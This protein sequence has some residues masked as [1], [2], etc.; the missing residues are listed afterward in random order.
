MSI[1]GIGLMSGTSL[2]GIDVAMVEI[3]GSDYDI[4]INLI[5]SDFLSYPSFVRELLLELCEPQTSSVDK[6]CKTNAYLG[7]LIGERVNHLIEKSSIPKEKICFVSSHGQTIFHIPPEATTSEWE[8]PSTFQI[9]DISVISEVTGLPVV[10]DFRPAEMAAGGQGAPLVSY[11]DYV[12][13]R[14]T[15]KNRAVQN[16]GG[17]GNVTHLPANGKPE[18]VLSFDT[19]PGNI[20]L[21]AVVERI[22]NGVKMYDEGG[23]LAAK[24]SISENLLQELMKHPYFE[25]APP[26][27]TGRELFNQAFI[28]HLWLR[29]ADLKVERND[30]IATLT[31]WTAMSI[32]KGYEK[33]LLNAGREIDEV[34][35]CG[36]G[37]SNKTLLSYL[38]EYLPEQRILTSEDIGIPSD[39]KEAIAFALLGY[40]CI[41]GNSNTLPS[42]TGA[43]HSVIMGKISCT[44]PEAYAKLVSLI[45]IDNELSI[46]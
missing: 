10:G 35:I 8:I 29:A 27:T 24:G 11:F 7:K 45:T 13:Y 6:I 9:G 38:S 1:Y 26:K 42:A 17:I 43:Q 19:G 36:G 25:Q 22:T 46:N 39:L 16:I 40:H 23:A 21:D 20:V 33:F 5:D 18:E 37:S 4:I 14:D 28:E 34:V 41:K 32:A 31:A 30:L 3:E 2:D 44:Q 12:C 15:R